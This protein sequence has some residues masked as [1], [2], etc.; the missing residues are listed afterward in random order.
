MG[1]AVGVP[2]RRRHFSRSMELFCQLPAEEP[3]GRGP[4]HDFRSPLVVPA[5]ALFFREV[6]RPELIEISFMS[7]VVTCGVL[8][9]CLQAKVRMGSSGAA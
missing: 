3:R 9:S 7:H 1:Q 4:Q 2:Q 5:S 6:R 8:E